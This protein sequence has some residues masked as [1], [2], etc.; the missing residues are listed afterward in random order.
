MA[1][2]TRAMTRGVMSLNVAVYRMSKGRMMG[3]IKKMPILLLT[4]PGRK[5]GKLHTAPVV[6]MEDNGRYVVTGSNGGAAEE[7]G[8][9][10]NLRAAEQSGAPV[11]L[12][13]RHKR[14]EASVSVAD[15][16]ERTR[17]WAQLVSQAP[18]F[19]QSYQAKTER[20]IPMAVLT[21]L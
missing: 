14:M 17:L 8:W 7:P 2:L 18:F 4:V 15:G 13:D 1:N 11:T 6:Y 19:E 9:F 5:T 3:R 10:R 12:E 16:E 21:P 20:Q